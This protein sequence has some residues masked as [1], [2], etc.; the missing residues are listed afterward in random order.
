MWQIPVAL[1]STST[2]PAFGPS[3]SSSTISSGFFASNAT[4]ARVFILNSCC[5]CQHHKTCRHPRCARS[6]LSHASHLIPVQ[7]DSACG[8]GFG[9][10][11]MAGRPA[12]WN[13]IVGAGAQIDIDVVDVAH[14]I[15][16]GG[17]GRH[18]LVI[19]GIDILAAVGDDADEVRIAERL[20]GF[21][22]RRRIA[23]A[24]AI[25]AMADMAV[26]MIA[27]EAGEGVPV[28]G[29]VRADLVGRVAVL[30]QILAIVGGGDRRIARRFGAGGCRGQHRSQARQHDEREF[31]GELMTSRK[32]VLVAH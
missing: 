16:V 26:R 30:I 10:V 4:A 3:R 21:G 31:P 28:D 22:Q 23:R 15:D 7:L 6:R 5:A 18:H 1:I 25:G 32:T 29:A 9:L 12:A 14:H 13:G 20:E 24:L 2:S 8:G 19:G 27:A 17:E 11:F